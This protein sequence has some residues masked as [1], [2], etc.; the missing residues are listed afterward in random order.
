MK[1]IVQLI[2]HQFVKNEAQ[3][4]LI[5]WKADAQTQL[6]VLTVASTTGLGPMNTRCEKRKKKFSKLKLQEI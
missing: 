5:M 4:V 6:N 3:V 1:V 2:M